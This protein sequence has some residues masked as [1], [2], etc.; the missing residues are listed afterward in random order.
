MRRVLVVDDEELIRE[1]V[2]ATLDSAGWH[3]EV[4]AGALEAK[5]LAATTAFDVALIDVNLGGGS[6]VDLGHALL[7]SASGAPPAIVFVSG[8]AALTDLPGAHGFLAKP[9]LPG[10]LLDAVERCIDERP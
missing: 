9:F 7:A 1:L 8:D 4:A 6:G 5:R 2:L 3:V 10:E